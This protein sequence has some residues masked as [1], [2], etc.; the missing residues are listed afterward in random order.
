MAKSFFKPRSKKIPERRQKP[1]VAL[2]GLAAIYHSRDCHFVNI[3]NVSASGIG[4]TCLFHWGMDDFLD[5]SFGLPSVPN[6]I[7]PR[8]RIVRNQFWQGKSHW[9]LQFTKLSNNDKTQ[10]EIYVR[11]HSLAQA[12]KKSFN[13]K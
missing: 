10:L 1:R 8:A 7:C 12:H 3:V 9:G 4:V 5:L 13:N 2:E 11:S 6:L